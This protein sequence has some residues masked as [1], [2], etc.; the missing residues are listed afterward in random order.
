MF[1]LRHVALSLILTHAGPPRRLGPPA[2]LT[3][4]LKPLAPPAVVLGVKLVAFIL[5]GAVACPLGL[6]AFGALWGGMV[7][8]APCQSAPSFFSGACFDGMMFLMQFGLIAAFI[9]A[10][11][12]GVASTFIERK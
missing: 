11:G 7:R 3:P 5:A 8:A 2:P 6:T 12:G 10:V 9:G 4:L 1:T